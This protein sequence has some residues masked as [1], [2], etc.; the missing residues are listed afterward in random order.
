MRC[1]SHISSTALFQ[2]GI[3]KKYIDGL[4]QD[5]S[6]SIANALGLLQP[7]DKPVLC[8]ARA[9]LPIMHRGLS[10]K[11]NLSQHKEVYGKPLVSY[12]LL[13][14]NFFFC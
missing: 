1:Q 13:N 4:A 9:N 11:I 2:N 10:Y 12:D 7:C 5:C 6:K 8:Y 14:A 3:P